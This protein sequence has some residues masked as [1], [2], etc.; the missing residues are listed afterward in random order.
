MLT[1]LLKSSLQTQTF[2]Y[3]FKYIKRG[4]SLLWA[5]IIKSYSIVTSLKI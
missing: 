3:K 5:K 4:T 2:E 1:K